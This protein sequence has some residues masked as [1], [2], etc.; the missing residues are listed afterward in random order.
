MRTIKT[1]VILLLILVAASIIYIYSGTYNIAATSPHSGLAEWIFNTTK[2]YSVRKHAEDIEPPKLDEERLVRAGFSHYDDM[3]AGCHGAPGS[4]PAEGFN[5]SP[6]DLSE[7]VPESRP[8][9][10]FWIIKNG[11]K[12]TGMPEFG[13]THSDDE[14]W[15][16][17]AFTLKLPELTEK[18]YNILKEETEHTGHEHDHQKINESQNDMVNDKENSNTK[19]DANEGE[20]HKHTDGKDHQH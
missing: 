1:I 8:A 3:C 7:A 12:M 13:S 2:K 11:I 14:L 17:V 5:P 20:A 16:I 10:L 9:E 15:G 19:T 6:P 18:Q 4:E